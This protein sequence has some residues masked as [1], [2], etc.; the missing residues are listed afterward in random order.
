MLFNGY[1]T[2]L[3]VS[4]NTI[5]RNGEDLIRVVVEAVIPYVRQ[6]IVTLD[7]NSKDST[8]YILREMQLK[9]KN[10]E[11]YY[12]PVGRFKRDLVEMRNRQF[13]KSK[14]K[15][16]WVVD[17]DEYYQSE[18]IEGLTLSDEYDVYA[19]RCWAPWNIRQAHRASSKPYIPRIFKSDGR[20][21][22][23][24]WGKEQLIQAGDRVKNLPFRYIHLTHF[25]KDNWRKEF[26]MERVAD[27]KHLA[28]MPEEI[29]KVMEKLYGQK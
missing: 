27:G 26:K 25:K 24:G 7:S 8:R 9:H 23:G 14:S 10:L 18:D 15:W 2:M 21:W 12:F 6:Y 13:E 16:M 11:V 28:P 29:I 1:K 22:R 20:R 3:D 5:V 17:S 19:L 4:V